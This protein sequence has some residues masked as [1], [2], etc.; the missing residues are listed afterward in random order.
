MLAEDGKS[1]ELLVYVLI[2]VMK[3][4]Q[5]NGKQRIS[6]IDEPGGDQYTPNSGICKPFGW[7]QCQL[8][9]FESIQINADTQT[10]EVSAS[11]YGA[12]DEL[13]SF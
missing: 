6:S 12:T 13:V 4:A 9:T 1:N 5:P 8:H 7:R 2:Q 11:V 3:G 10:L